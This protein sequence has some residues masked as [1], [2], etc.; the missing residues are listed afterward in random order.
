MQIGICVPG[1]RGVFHVKTVTCFNDLQPFGIEALTGEACAL[2]YRILFDVTEKG[3]AV[4]RKTFGIPKMTFAE[5]WN[6]GPK[7]NEHI[8]SI[9]LTQEALIPIAILALLESGC[10]ECYVLNGIVIG[11]EPGDPPGPR[12]VRPAALPRPAAGKRLP[13]DV[14]GAIKVLTKTFSHRSQHCCAC[15]AR[16]RSCDRRN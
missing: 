1:P 9:M 4:I 5:A 10:T 15:A 8:G 16:S 6:R 3:A 11:L 13:A 7:G 12:R 14:A 2:W